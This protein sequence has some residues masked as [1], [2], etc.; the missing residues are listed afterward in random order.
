MKVTEVPG[1]TELAE[2]AIATLTG[3]LSTTVIVTAL[4]VFG[5]P[6]KQG[7]ALEVIRQDTISP[8]TGVKVKLALL[9]PEGVPFIFHW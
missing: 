2:T 1:Q 8:C 4:E 3:R 9:V 5:L 6:V 7:V